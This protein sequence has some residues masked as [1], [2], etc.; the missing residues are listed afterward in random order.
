MGISCPIPTYSE[1]GCIDEVLLDSNFP[2]QISL[3]NEARSTK[4]ELKQN[5]SESDSSC[6][7]VSQNQCPG[8]MPSG[9]KGL[10][11]KFLNSELPCVTEVDLSEPLRDSFLQNKLSKTASSL[12]DSPLGEQ[13][14]GN[15]VSNS[16]S[17]VQH[18][19]GNLSLCYGTTI[20]CPGVNN[21]LSNY[22]QDNTSSFNHNY[23]MPTSILDNSHPLTSCHL[24]TDSLE[25]KLS[26]S[27]LLC[28]TNQASSQSNKQNEGCLETR[29][30]E[31]NFENS[32]ACSH[33][34]KHKESCLGTG[35]QKNNVQH[36]LAPSLLSEQE[37]HNPEVFLQEQ[38]SE[39]SSILRQ[40]RNSQGTGPLELG[41]EPSL[42]SKSCENKPEI[43]PQGFTSDSKD[44]TQK[45]GGNG[46]SISPSFVDVQLTDTSADDKQIS[47]DPNLTI[48]R[49]LKHI[50]TGGVEPDGP[51]LESRELKKKLDN[52]QPDELPSGND[53][54]GQKLFVNKTV[55]IS[56]KIESSPMLGKETWQITGSG[57]LGKTYPDL[58][59]SETNQSKDIS[60]QKDRFKDQSLETEPTSVSISKHK[61]LISDNIDL[62]A[63]EKVPDGTSEADTLDVTDNQNQEGLSYA[64]N[65]SC[66]YVNGKIESHRGKFLIDTG[67]S[68]S[69]IGTKVLEHLNLD[70]PIQPADRKVRK[71]NGGLLDV[72]GRCNLE[73][74]LDHLTFRQDFIIADIEESLGILGINF[75][76]E[77]G[78]D[79]KIRKRLLKTKQGK[80]KLHKRGAQVCNKLQLCENVT[81]PAQSEA[82][83]KAYMPE[84]SNIQY[85]LLE[86]TNRYINQGLLIARTLIDTSDDQM[87]VSVLNISDKNV[88]LRE[89]TTLGIAHPVDQISNSSNSTECQT[90][91]D[92]E[93]KS[94]HKECPE[95]LEPLLQNLSPD[96]KSDEKQKVSQLLEE[97]QDVFMSP[98]GKLGQTCLAEHYIDTGD[99]KPFKLPC[100]RIPLFKRP[101]IEK[102]ISKMLEQNVIEPS[103]SPWNS[104]ICLVSKKQT[105]EW[106]FCVDLRALNS[107]TKLDTYPLP[108]IDETLER[109][110]NS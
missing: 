75:L 69:V 62:S 72:K 44:L 36:R 27:S 67:S 26:S 97:F 7:T 29:P 3:K 13:D 68:V 81:I 104:P 48:Q 58:L 4:S 16:A 24:G 20:A 47:Q 83:V 63:T 19:Q 54:S 2:R 31:N 8:L 30:L 94:G 51:L 56:L 85:S 101:I 79:V 9:I 59:V 77:N 102:E 28:E 35:P 14:L 11:S 64:I 65:G 57:A 22:R 32:L 55:S 107:I 103:A 18:S 106:R 23:I 17:S 80:I 38:Q 76:D 86:P 42:V 73:I 21:Q 5:I 84:N 40:Y 60:E 6:G 37:K 34:S 15:L 90:G 33:V 12:H 39:N 49:S 95:F 110:S 61:L 50:C 71:A 87:T 108:R 100:H 43:K 78:A 92:C 46:K 99:H 105:G 70:I 109:L 82:F 98:G 93:I 88:K 91:P 10:G 25:N 89:S 53:S 41:P 74:Q 96:L 1:N 45:S 52:L 66:Y